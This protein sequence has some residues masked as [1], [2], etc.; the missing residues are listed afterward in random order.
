[1]G[2]RLP[3]KQEVAGSSPAPPIGKGPAN[4]GPCFQDRQRTDGRGNRMAT[5][6][7]AAPEAEELRRVKVFDVLTPTRY[8]SAMKTNSNNKDFTDLP[9]SP[10]LVVNLRAM[11]D[12][13]LPIQE[14][15]GAGLAVTL[16]VENYV[17]YLARTGRVAGKTWEE[18]ASP[19]GITRQ[20]AYARYGHGLPGELGVV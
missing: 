13:S 19:L 7:L 6:D 5:A 20:T 14:R 11:Y 4:A 2:E 15:L 17:A 1:L 10:N 8:G 12:D 18:I 16:N 9:L 3:Y